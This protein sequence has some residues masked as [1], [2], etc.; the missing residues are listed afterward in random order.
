MIKLVSFRGSFV[1]PECLEPLHK[2]D[3]KGKDAGWKSLKIEACGFGDHDFEPLSALHTG[4]EIHMLVDAPIASL[5][6]VAIPLG[7]IPWNRYPVEDNNKHIFHYYGKWAPL[8]D[9]LHSEGRGEWAWSSF[10]GA[11]LLEIGAWRGDKPV[12]RQIQ[13]HLHRLGI[14]CGPIDGVVGE[15][16]LQALKNLG[17]SELKPPEILEKIQDWDFDPV[18]KG[19]DEVGYLYLA[20]KPAQV[21]TSGEVRA[22]QS[23]NGYTI[24]LE[25]SG[26]I[27]VHVE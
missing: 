26:R 15:R 18:E 17:L 11:S 16:T 13:M 22:I 4:R 8:I 25:G 24:S 2:L 6:S 5:W 14:H 20:G 7:F 12:E 21:F 23:H 1:H 19:K 10:C 3:R 27:I 9:S